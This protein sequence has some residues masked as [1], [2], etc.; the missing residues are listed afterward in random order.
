MSNPQSEPDQWIEI[1]HS[2]PS[3]KRCFLLEQL[4]DG[5]YT[6]PSLSNM[7]VDASHIREGFRVYRTR[8]RRLEFV[9]TNGS[10]REWQDDNGRNYIIDAI[11]GR[12][13]VEHGI[14][15]VD[16]ADNAACRQAVLRPDD[17]HIHLVF[18]AD[19]WDKCFCN[20]KVNN[21]DWTPTPGQQMKTGTGPSGDTTAPPEQEGKFFYIVIK[22]KRLVCAFSDGGENWDSKQGFN[23][24]LGLPGRYHVSGGEI[25]YVSPAFTDLHE[26]EN[27]ASSKHVTTS[28]KM[29]SVYGSGKPSAT[30]SSVTQVASEVSKV[31]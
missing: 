2:K 10:N 16:D 19:L 28:T 25:R 23:Y 13:V 12:Y 5:K 22:G 21:E 8:S 30:V 27:A 9:L 29:G 17:S 31:V 20:F 1:F 26:E 24:M 6:D 7:L 3:M 11:P 4:A 14:R 15:R 18:R